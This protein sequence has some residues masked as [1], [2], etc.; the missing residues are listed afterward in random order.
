MTNKI[1]EHVE[2]LFQG[3]PRTARAV[4]L[5]EELIANLL[6]RYADLIQQGNDE[7]DAYSIVVAGIGDV[8][9]LIRGL[10]EQEVFNP[11]NIQEQRQR[12]A[13]LISIAVA[14]YIV[15]FIFP[16]VFFFIADHTGKDFPMVF[17]VI[18]MLLCW[19]AATGLLVFNSMSKPKYVKMEETIVE[20]FKEWKQIKR[21]SET[22]GKSIQSVVW[23]LTVPLFLVLGFAFN[24]WHP[25]WL[26]FVLAPA[27]NQIIKLVFLYREGN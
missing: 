27:V 15:S 9:E 22:L 6:D 17:G 10:Q 16:T 4:E 11:A 13:L 2:Y 18:L 19:A 1:R 14:L 5:K 24:A 26:V 3:A 12:S 20:D 21:N 8:E 23:T 25:G 7:E